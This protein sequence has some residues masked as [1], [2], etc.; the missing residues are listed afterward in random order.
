[1]TMRTNVHAAAL[2][3]TIAVA[4]SLLPSGA[5]A[6]LEVFAC[7]PEW[8]SLARELGGE[9]V[10]VYQASTAYQDPHRIEAR[11]SLV[12]RMRRAQLVVCTGADLEVGWLP[13]LMQSAANP[14]V[15]HGTPGFLEAAAL[16][17][18]LD[19]PTNVDRA[20][21]D[22]HPYGNPHV[23]LDPR[24][25]A[26]IAAALSARLGELDGANAAG[27]R[28]RG[29]D[30]QA[31]WA[32]AIA[33]WEAAAAPLRGLKYVAYHK[34]V[35]YFARWIGLVEVT[36]I[37]PKPGL[38][39]TASH[40]AAL[41]GQLGPGAADVITRLPFE[42]PKPAQWLASR[43]GLP[44]VSLPYTVGGSATATDLFALFDETLAALAAARR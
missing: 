15:R 14:H 26:R 28:S 13:V 34:D 2:T 22:V 39:P 31:R 1:M 3:C 17:E 12:A 7:E 16:V 23:H 8:A 29:D 6:A 43:T 25:V 4:A 27:Y 44:I 40:L 24:N 30:F 5:S 33:R 38:P 21:G 9:A 10:D 42:D 20:E 41:V 36:T 35:A 19:V 18:R 32:Q 11:P 37:E